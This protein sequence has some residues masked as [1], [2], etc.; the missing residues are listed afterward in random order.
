MYSI[1]KILRESLLIEDI[2]LDKSVMSKLIKLGMDTTF[3]GDKES[4]KNYLMSVIGK[5][6]KLPNKLT[7]Y[8]VVFVDDVKDI[9][10]KNIGSHYVMNKR[11]L[12]Q[13]HSS[14]S[15]VGGGKPFLLT[16]RADKSLIDY[17]ETLS[18]LI[19]YPNEDE[20]TLLN[21]GNGAHILDVSDFKGDEFSLGSDLGFDDFELD[22]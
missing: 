8:R 18:N 21:N 19:Q 2:N 16:V 9:N 17:V 11:H 14:K 10:S 22:Y 15:H 5:L 12:E 13:V 1:K 20:I 4:S 3:D 7:L 6:N